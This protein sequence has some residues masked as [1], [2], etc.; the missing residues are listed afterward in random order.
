MVTTVV[1]TWGMVDGAN[2]YL[3]FRST[4]PI[5]NIT[6]QTFIANVT[7]NIFVDAITVNGYYYYAV[8]AGNGLYNSSVSNSPGVTVQIPASQTPASIDPTVPVVVGIMCGTGAFFAG[9]LLKLKLPRK[10]RS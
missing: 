8:V 5:T 1:V 3:V 6:G 2:W 10:K 9:Y 4:L 7:G